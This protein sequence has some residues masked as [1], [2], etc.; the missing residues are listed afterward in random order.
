MSL[1][2][3]GFIAKCRKYLNTRKKCIVH[4]SLSGVWSLYEAIMY[5]SEHLKQSW[6][7][8]S[9]VSCSPN[10]LMEAVLAIRW[11]GDEWRW[12]KLRETWEGRGSLFPSYWRKKRS[13]NSYTVESHHSP[14]ESTSQKNTEGQASSGNHHAKWQAQMSRRLPATLPYH[15]GIL[16]HRFWGRKTKHKWKL[17]KI[18]RNRMESL[19][20]LQAFN[21]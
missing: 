18:Q 16:S 13:V 17:T 20:F 14:P 3:K 6:W 11:K 4:R 19:T 7:G 5:K 2:G 21:P 10:T 1:T 12:G 9:S 8:I 15:T